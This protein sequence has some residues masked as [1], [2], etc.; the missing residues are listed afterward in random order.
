MPKRD[1]ISTAQV[2]LQTGRLKIARELRHGA[3][4]LRELQSFRMRVDLRKGDQG[5]SWREGRND[6]L[7]LALCVGLWVG[8]RYKGIPCGFSAGGFSVFGTDPGSDDDSDLGWIG[9]W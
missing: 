4:L 8:E 6:D 5:L 3:L 1:V 2:M 7:V 9:P